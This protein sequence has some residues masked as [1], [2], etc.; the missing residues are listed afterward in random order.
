MFKYGKGL[1]LV[2]L[3][4]I[5]LM[6]CGVKKY[7]FKVDG[8]VLDGLSDV[9][10]EQLHEGIY[11]PMVKVSE[12]KATTDIEDSFY[13]LDGST[14]IIFGINPKKDPKQINEAEKQLISQ[15]VHD[16]TSQLEMTISF[17]DNNLENPLL[18]KPLL[19]LRHDMG[20]P[21][22]KKKDFRN[23]GKLSEKLPEEEWYLFHIKLKDNVTHEAAQGSD[24]TISFVPY[25]SNLKNK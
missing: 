1:L 11:L 4:T 8:L 22:R 16:E 3:S 21:Y 9:T 12:K 13:S 14:G 5:F 24:F 20:M 2:M 25:K 6:S 19:S 15:E 18:M 17:V 23:P 10:D 7:D